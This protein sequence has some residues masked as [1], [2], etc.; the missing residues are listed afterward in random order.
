VGTSLDSVYSSTLNFIKDKN[1][2]FVSKVHSNFGFGIGCKYKEDELSIN[3]NNST[4]VEP[5]MA[6]HVRMSF[7]EVD[8]Q[9]SRSIVA[10]GDTVLIDQDGSVSVVTQA[11]PRKYQ[12]ISY[13]FED[14]EEESEP[15]FDKK[16]RNGVGRPNTAIDQAAV[17]SGRTRNSAKQN[18]KNL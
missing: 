17:I 15:E 5:G 7:R 9:K 18:T 6:F 10:I 12:H 4:K 8:K 1:P 2:T 3:P 14:D 16:E 11:I 13:K